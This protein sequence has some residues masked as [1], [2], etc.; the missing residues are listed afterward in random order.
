MHD[1]D[2]PAQHVAIGR[3]HV[4]RGK[5]AGMTFDADAQV[6]D[7]VDIG[8]FELADEEAAARMRDQQALLLQQPRSLAHRGTADAEFAGDAGLDDLGAGQQLSLDDGLGQDAR[9]LADKIGVGEGGQTNWRSNQT[10]AGDPFHPL[11]KN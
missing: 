5:H 9:D 10:H 2:L 11:Y 3:R 8:R 1:V 7:L 6:V 4:L